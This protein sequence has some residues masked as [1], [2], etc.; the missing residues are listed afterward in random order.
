MSDLNELFYRDTYAREFEATVVSCTETDKGFEVIL[1]DTAFYPEGGGQPADHGKLGDA[2]VTDT[3]RVAGQIVHTTDKALT[4][5]TVVKGVLDWARRFD[6]MQNH[7]GEHI[8]S[9]LVHKK[10]G[11]DNVGFHMD[12]DVITVDFD[13]V[14]S[15]EELDEIEIQV[16]NA[17][18]ADIPVN[19]LFPSADELKVTDYRSKKELTGKVRIVD[20]PGCDRCAC[21]GTHVAKTGEIGILKIT[22]SEK[23]RGG[24]RVFF[25]CGARAV[26]DFA[27]KN[28]S[29]KHISE[30]LSTKPAEVADAVEKLLAAQATKDGELAQMKKKLLTF[31]AQALPAA[32]K[33]LITFEDGMTPQELRTLATVI[34]EMKKAPAAAV[35][36]AT[37][38][39]TFSY[40]LWGPTQ[41]MRDISK[42]LN[43]E[44]NGR[45]GGN[46]G[47]VQGSY[48]ASEDAVRTAINAAFAAL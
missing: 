13:G 32:D 24:T 45:G 10:F 11:F 19:I 3:R 25:V 20:I 26:R 36:S 8:I 9:G 12:D 34:S 38:P 44:L 22:G 28:E 1:T 47:F 33:V 35:L 27:R 18:A 23:H 46:G 30:L 6:N 7:T 2:L 21:C 40:V 29:V 43:Q 39:D 31:K 4:A 17:I 14:V 48:K 42:N 16:N 37:G 5:G 15:P 41:A